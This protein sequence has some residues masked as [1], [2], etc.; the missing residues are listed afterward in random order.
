MCFNHLKFHASSILYWKAC[1]QQTPVMLRNALRE[2]PCTCNITCRCGFSRQVNSG[3]SFGYIVVQYVSTYYLNHTVNTALGFIYISS[4]TQ[5]YQH[6]TDNS[7]TNNCLE[8]SIIICTICNRWVTKSY[9]ISRFRWGTTWM[10]HELY[11]W[12][13]LRS[14]FLGL[15]RADKR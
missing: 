3:N 13:C 8:K 10:P 11:L 6:N 5:N 7:L 15:A 14:R 9:P 12:V 2:I 4:S 1:M